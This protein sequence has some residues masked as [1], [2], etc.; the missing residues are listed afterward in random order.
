LATRI[1]EQ[2]A[3]GTATVEIKSGYGLTIADEFGALRIAG[4]FTGESTFLG[5]HV[6]PTE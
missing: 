3:L 1:A 6:V 4:E 5:A 2:R